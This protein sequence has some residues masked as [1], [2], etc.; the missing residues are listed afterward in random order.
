M[1]KG[2]SG[3]IRVQ[4]VKIFT[5]TINICTYVRK[6][7]YLCSGVEDEG[8]VF[9]YKFMKVSPKRVHHIIT[10]YKGCLSSTGSSRCGNMA[11]KRTVLAMLTFLCTLLIGAQTVTQVERDTVRGS[12]RI[13]FPLSESRI[14]P[15][16]DGNR[17]QLDSLNS[18]LN[19]LT[20]DTNAT[21]LSMSVHGYG[22]ID[23][24]YKR[25]DKLSR[26]RTDSIVAYIM[27]RSVLPRNLIA[28]SSTAED[29][30]GFAEYVK[31]ANKE[32]LPHRDG[33]LKII[34]SSRNP[35]G[36]EWAIKQMYPADYRR[37]VADCL[38]QLRRA[39]CEVDYM[40]VRPVA[41]EPV[42]EKVEETVVDT[43]PAEPTEYTIK[44]K[45]T[46]FYV[47]TNLLLPLLNVGVELPLGNRWSIAA[48]WYYPWIFRNSDHKNCFQIDGLSLEG[49]YW[50][51]S[52]HTSGVENKQYR[53]QGHSVAGF[54][55]AGRYDLERNYSG[56]Q[57][58]YLL[59]GVDYLWAKPIFKGKMHLELSFGVGFLYSWARHYNVYVE[60]GKAYRNKNFRKRFS[61]FGPLR[62]SV[63]LVI[64]INWT[65]TKTVYR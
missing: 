7:S 22:S 47:R 13:S 61:Y 12:V 45:R 8:V 30:D 11:S 43:V 49:R 63:S 58:E 42:V 27:R 60:G 53:L 50:F 20:V 24:M 6:K 15:E 65:T 57:G 56:H 31:N 14:S 44:Q 64:P 17:R 54:V 34:G 2:G 36:K 4:S 38:P 10:Y 29:W 46:L 51:G 48:D 21:V 28:V 3:K 37:L 26:E 32:Q 39:Y 40:I 19:T 16:F 41:P 33:I 18:I 25:N 35:D 5:L 59:G 23:G 62:A 52:K 1:P 9:V 55:M